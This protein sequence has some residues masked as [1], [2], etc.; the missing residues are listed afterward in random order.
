[1]NQKCPKPNV[2]CAILFSCFKTPIRWWKV[3][4]FALLHILFFAFLPAAL[5]K[6]SNA[7]IFFGDFLLL[8]T[9]LGINVGAH[10]YCFLFVCKKL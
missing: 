10:R 6:S 5:V 4:A 9:V 2:T 3:L 7:T 8:V 1:M